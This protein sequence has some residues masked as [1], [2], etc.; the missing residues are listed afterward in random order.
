MHNDLIVSGIG[1]NGENVTNVKKYTSEKTSTLNAKGIRQ[2]ENTAEVLMN[3]KIK[4]L[5]TSLEK[6]LNNNNFIF[7]IASLKS[8]LDNNLVEDGA[9]RK[10]EEVL[11]VLEKEENET[12]CCSSEAK[13]QREGFKNDKEKSQN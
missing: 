6:F 12:S 3:I 7:H 10:V 1:G 4:I 8:P 9:K 2:S 13:K 11:I 5:L